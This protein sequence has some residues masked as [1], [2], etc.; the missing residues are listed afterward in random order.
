MNLLKNLRHIPKKAYHTETL[1]YKTRILAAGGTISERSLDYTEKF[2]Q[3][4]KNALTWD[5]LE[6]VGLF[7]GDQ[8]TAGLVKLKY[9]NNSLLINN[10]FTSGNYVERGAN[11]GL[12]G[13]G[14]TKYLDPGYNLQELPDNG[15]FSF[16]LREDVSAAG[17]RACMGAFGDTEHF[18]LGSLTSTD[19]VLG[20][21]G[22]LYSALA[23]R[24]FNKGH[25]LLSRTASDNL[26]FHL[27]GVKIAQNSNSF[28]IVK[29]NGALLLWA[30]N[31]LDGPNIQ[32]H[33]PARGSFYSIGQA[34]SVTEA[35]AFYGA[36]QT[37]QRNL[38]RQI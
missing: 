25:Y 32:N 33:L 1:D 17:N 38:S 16:Y 2:V 37:L 10:N 15:H 20:Q 29:P 26:D 12:L 14:V 19:N 23:E 11:G 22:A 35:A 4:C 30:W 31:Y 7:L 34:L 5:K 21:Y 27:N 6:E 13:D 8:L 28:S 9:R 18:V 24:P 3:D 36:V